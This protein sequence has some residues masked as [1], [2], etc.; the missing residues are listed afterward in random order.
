MWKKFSITFKSF[1]IEFLPF[2]QE[3]K[4]KEDIIRE[5]ADAATMERVRSMFILYPPFPPSPPPPPLSPACDYPNSTNY[6]GQNLTLACRNGSC[7]PGYHVRVERFE[8]TS[9]P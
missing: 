9:L 7:P 1:D 8:G 5:L 4:A 2:I 6:V 3:I